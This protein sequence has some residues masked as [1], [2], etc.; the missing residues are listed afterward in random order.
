MDDI[1]IYGYDEYEMEELK[2]SLDIEMKNFGL[3]LNSSKTKIDEIGDIDDSIFVFDYQIDE[4]KN[5]YNMSDD[6]TNLSGQDGS[7]INFSLNSDS[8][9]KEKSLLPIWNS[10]SLAHST[11][12]DLLQAQNENENSER[13]REQQ[14]LR[15]ASSF[16]QCLSYLIDNDPFGVELEHLDYQI[17]FDLIDKFFGE[18]IIGVGV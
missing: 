15:N 6:F 14:I 8:G 16:R 11:I 10:A 18:L 2:V 1:R 7:R 5:Y 4:N 3:T 12:T 9:D 17:W 13:N